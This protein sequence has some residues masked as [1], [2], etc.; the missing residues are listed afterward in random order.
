MSK[1]LALFVCLA[2]AL[3]V[4][5]AQTPRPDPFAEHLFTVELVM[6]NATDIGLDERQRATI[7]ETVQKAQAR[8]LDLQ[9]DTQAESER[10]V[11]LL[12]ARP[13]DE[14]AVLAQADRI[15][16]LE[17]EIKKAHLALLV[18]IKNLLTQPQ[19]ERLS[20]LQRKARNN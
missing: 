11:R 14:A 4:A 6:R 10:M 2:A 3:A 19:Q 15:L 8:L 20:D 12:Q 5:N 13:V 9:W 1:L 7:K 18:R 17:R 16:N